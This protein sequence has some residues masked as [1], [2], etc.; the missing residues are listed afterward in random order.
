MCAAAQSTVVHHGAFPPAVPT[1]GLG[2]PS[3]PCMVGVGL[4]TLLLLLGGCG[5][6]LSCIP[7]NI[8]SLMSAEKTKGFCQL[9][10]SFSLRD[11][12]SHLIQSAG[13]G[14]LKHNTVL[15]AWPASWKQEDNPFSWKNF[16]DTVRD[17]TAAH[18]ALLVAKNIDAFPQN[19]E[20]FSGGH[21]DV[22]WIVHDGGMLM[23][24]PFLLRQHKVWRK[25]RMR[26]FTVAQV[27]DN[28]IQMKKDLQMFL[29]H[30][31]ISAEVEVV[32]M[33][34]E[35]EEEEE[36]VV[37]NVARA[38]RPCGVVEEAWSWEQ[39]CTSLADISSSLGVAA[40]LEP[41]PASPC[42][43]WSRVLL[44]PSRTGFC[45]RPHVSVAFTM[46]SIC[47][48]SPPIVS[49]HLPSHGAGACRA[50]DA[51]PPLEAGW[52]WRRPVENDISAFTYERTLM[53]EQRSQMLKQMQ[54]SKNE[55]EREVRGCRG[56]D[57]AFR[58]AQLALPSLS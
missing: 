25:C 55:Q 4:H 51:W 21:I 20:R 41:A 33:G 56:R 58:D 44:G 9:V 5:T 47:A 2:V 17:T 40:A 37:A 3:P 32:E 8:R 23:L 24:L 28:S 52:W 35:E 53:M 57:E 29:Y 22:W 12:M 13:L 45:T 39:P 7:Q 50:P 16:V 43:P 19:Q 10:V 15:M 27:D 26:I 14:G 36:E 48:M 49:S 6:D 18:Q 30:L 34:E 1:V 54:L 46:R 42:P 11:G 38:A 31:R